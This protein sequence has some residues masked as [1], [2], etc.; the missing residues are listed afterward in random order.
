MYDTL[1]ME[2]VLVALDYYEE[3]LTLKI[4]QPE[5]YTL[6]GFDYV[7]VFVA[8]VAVLECSYL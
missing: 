3:S 8:V 1:Y 2:V 6:V 7:S 5:T 4:S